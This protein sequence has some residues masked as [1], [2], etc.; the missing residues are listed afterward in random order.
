MARGAVG[1]RRERDAVAPAEQP[2]LG[3]HHVERGIAC[4]DRRI[5]DVDLADNL[6]KRLLGHVHLGSLA[7]KDAGNMVPDFVDAPV[8]GIDGLARQ[9]EP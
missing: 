7:S 5:V 6:A 4:L 2:L 3:E 9:L 1:Y 8:D